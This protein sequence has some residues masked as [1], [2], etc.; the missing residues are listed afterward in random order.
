MMMFA[1]I[2]LDDTQI[3]HHMSLDQMNKLTGEG[4]IAPLVK[5]SMPIGNIVL[6]E[7]P[8]KKSFGKAVSASVHMESN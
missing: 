7:M 5:V 6:K 8:P 1:L 4:L 2:R 3:L